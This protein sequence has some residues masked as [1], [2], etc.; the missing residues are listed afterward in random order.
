MAYTAFRILFSLHSSCTVINHMATLGELG[1]SSFLRGNG[2]ADC[3]VTGIV[4][5]RHQRYRWHILRFRREKKRTLSRAIILAE[6]SAS[7]I[8]QAAEL[9]S[10]A[11]E[12]QRSVALNGV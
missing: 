4:T 11:R 7:E 8:T 10:R 1:I 2:E 9:F 5:S 3:R 6:D 12:V